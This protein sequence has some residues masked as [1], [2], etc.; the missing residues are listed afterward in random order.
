MDRA[1]IKSMALFPNIANSYCGREPNKAAD[2]P[3]TDDRILAVGF[4]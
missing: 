2:F 4:P 3:F 1:T